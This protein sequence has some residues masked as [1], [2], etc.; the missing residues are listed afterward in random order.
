M[1][2]VPLMMNAEEEVQIVIGVDLVELNAKSGV[3]VSDVCSTA[4]LEHTTT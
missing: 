1:I 4:T 2:N 3:S